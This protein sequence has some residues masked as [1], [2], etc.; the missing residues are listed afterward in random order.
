MTEKPIPPK[1]EEERRKE[2]EKLKAE[3]ERSWE[4][5]KAKL[6]H[7]AIEEVTKL[8]KRSALLSIRNR[9]EVHQRAMNVLCD[10]LK[11]Y[12]PAGSTLPY[13]MGKL[14]REIMRTYES[15]RTDFKEV[16]GMDEEK[17]EKLFPKIDTYFERSDGAMTILLVIMQQENQMN[18]YSIR[19]TS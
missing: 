10:A 9:I 4:A 18:A 8:R 19:M 14:V 17:L 1:S 7:G 16:M 12:V 3:A 11:T 5:A 13:E 15:I 6:A 2:T